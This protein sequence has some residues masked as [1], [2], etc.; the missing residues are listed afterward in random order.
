LF[1]RLS[2]L[3]LDQAEVVLY[4]PPGTSTARNMQVPYFLEEK[5]PRLGVRAGSL[6]ILMAEYPPPVQPATS[7][8]STQVTSP[9]RWA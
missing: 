3:P 6:G 9:C 1:D 8:T 7:M 2:E 5:P 4:E